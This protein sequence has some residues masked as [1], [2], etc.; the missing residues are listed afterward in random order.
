M[1]AISLH[2]KNRKWT[3]TFPRVATEQTAEDI[4]QPRYSDRIL[5]P[6]L[7]EI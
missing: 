3:T 5:T 4:W 6:D 2:S 1:V 7:A